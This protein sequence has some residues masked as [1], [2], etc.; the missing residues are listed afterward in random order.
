MNDPMSVEDRV[1]WVTGAAGGIG[2]AIADLFHE[3]GA[4]V[5]ATDR[6]QPEGDYQHS[7]AC[8]ITEPVAITPVIAAC[9]ALGGLDTLVNC[10]GVIHRADVFD[11]TPE[12]W[13]GLFAVN[14]EGSFRCAQAATRSM[15]AG[16][17][18]GTIIN[19]GS[20]NA[21]KVFPDT[22]AYCAS[23]GGLHAMTRAMAL[24]LAPHGIRVNT[25]APGAVTDTR[26]EPDRWSKDVEKQSMQTLTPLGTLAASA[27]IAPSVLFLSCPGAA[28]ITGATLF[29][30]GGRSASV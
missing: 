26:L 23:K 9:E 17:R 13:D 27:D 19:I 18:A 22:I 5:V 15:I 1:I 20:V 2:K 12:L 24:A 29:V 7:L 4:K 28:Q 14:V 21:Q 16:K 3:A 10:A 25:V 8:D 30:D 6:A 11:V